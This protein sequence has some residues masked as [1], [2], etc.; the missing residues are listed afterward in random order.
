[1][2][3]HS[4]PLVAAKALDQSIWLDF[5]QRS[6]MESG[7]LQ[8][9]IDNDHICGITSNPA[10]FENA[11]ANSSEY[12]QQ[13]RTLLGDQPAIPPLEIF[14]HLAISDIKAAADILK[15]VFDNS[16]GDDGM[17]SL[18]V[19]PTLAHDSDGTIREALELHKAVDRPNLMIKVPGTEAGVHAFEELTASGISVNVTLLFSLDRYRDIANAYITGLERRLADKAPVSAIASV[20]SF[21]VSRV[22]SRVD[23]RLEQHSDTSAATALLGKIAIANAK[24]SYL[25]YQNTFAGSRFA[26][27]KSHG[28]MPQRL[29]WASTGTKNPEY[30][31]VYYVEELMGPE[32]VNTL[33]PKTMDSFRDHGI[34]EPRLLNGLSS[35]EALLNS[36]HPLNIDLAAITKDLEAEGIAGF[37][38]AFERL[39]SAITEKSRHLA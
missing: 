37:A 7:E 12:D 30:R 18:E 24:A 39:L 14:K 19:S 35:S 2:Q 23:A 17:V 9:L 36:L 25:H 26:A 13:I 28:A 10:I 8:R 5:I 11:I 38:E 1:M 29:L 6:L 3:T 31:D 4:N 33:P 20:A 27:L 16:R 34:V 15:P 21:F 22:D 32:T